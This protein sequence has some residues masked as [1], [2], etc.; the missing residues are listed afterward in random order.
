MISITLAGST[1]KETDKILQ[2]HKNM[3]DAKHGIQMGVVLKGC[4]DAK[5]DLKNDWDESPAN[6]TCYHSNQPYAIKEDVLPIEECQQLSPSY[7]VRLQ[8]HIYRK[9]SLYL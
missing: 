1:M 8:K 3:T 4:D 5:D 7:M 2:M 6:F 9:Y